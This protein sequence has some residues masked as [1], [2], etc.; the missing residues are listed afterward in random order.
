MSA[1]KE[2]LK[3]YSFYHFYQSFFYHL[4]LNTSWIII[5]ELASK[6]KAED[7]FKFIYSEDIEI[8]SR[9]IIYLS[10]IYWEKKLENLFVVH[11]GHFYEKQNLFQPRQDNYKAYKR[12]LRWMLIWVIIRIGK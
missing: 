7:G 10:A 12:S 3:H 8:F 11:K 9:T 5:H 4:L 2:Y 6:E 1:K